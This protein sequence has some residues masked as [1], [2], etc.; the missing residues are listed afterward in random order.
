[1]NVQHFIE[2]KKKNNNDFL[3]LKKKI[4]I[5]PKETVYQFTHFPSG[6]IYFAKC[7]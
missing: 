6:W 2:K 4:L 7:Y 3:L 1:M 5:M